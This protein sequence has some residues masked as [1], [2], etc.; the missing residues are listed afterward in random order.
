MNATSTAQN[1]DF[2]Q[3]M[4]LNRAE[5]DDTTKAVGD[6]SFSNYHGHTKNTAKMNFLG[7]PANVHTIQNPASAP[8][9]PP[10]PIFPKRDE[11]QE[12]NEKTNMLQK[13][14]ENLEKKKAKLI[15]DQNVLSSPN[16]S[17][18]VLNLN[19]EGE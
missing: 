12:I 9:L 15:Q 8:E 14:L 19:V 17:P 1:R 5:G 10:L 6:T 7:T 11:L 3:F 18:A 4:S 13:E 16:P 2:S